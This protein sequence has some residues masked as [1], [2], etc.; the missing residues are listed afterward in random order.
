M[1]VY[2]C[3]VNTLVLCYSHSLASSSRKCLSSHSLACATLNDAT[4]LLDHRLVVV[5]V[6]VVT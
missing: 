2:S 4:G 3:I 6:A 1:N 5:V